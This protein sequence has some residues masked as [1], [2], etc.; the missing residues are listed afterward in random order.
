[1]TPR[2]I[3]SLVVAVVILWLAMGSVYVV[4]Q[5][6]V[7]VLLRFGR[8]IND[9]VKPGLHFKIPIADDIHKFD[10]RILTLDANP[11]SYF[12]TQKKRLIVDSYVKWR[13]KDPALYYRATGGSQDLAENRLNAQLND[14]LRNEVGVRTLHEVVS[15][16]REELM[17]ELQKSLNTSIARTMGVDV[18]DVRVKR[19]N[20]PDEVSQ[21]VFNRMAAER[22]KLAHKYR[23]EGKEEAEKIRAD[24]E[25]QRT[26]IEANAYEESERIRGEGDAK[27]AAIYAAA[28][29]KSP[30]FYAFTR[31]L[32][33]YRKS[34]KGDNDMLVLQPDSDFF[35]YLNKPSGAASK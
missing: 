34:F 17:H 15:G 16:Q 6:E 1:M 18:I 24:A 21:S 33:A 3:W 12:T 11:E 4:K 27:A 22:Q 8:L 25:R 26:V 28:Y 13:I 20:L 10:G 14:G 19:I 2:A 31:S 35:R 5:T 30:E 9:N 32:K 29:G 7:A 23:A